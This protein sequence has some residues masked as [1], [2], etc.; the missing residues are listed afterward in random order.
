MLW[1]LGLR[2]AFSA[3]I[4]FCSRPPGSW[5][6]ACFAGL[7]SLWLLHHHGFKQGVAWQ[8]ARDAE[9]AATINAEQPKITEII[10]KVYLPQEVKIKTVTQTIVK[11]VPVYVTKQD[12]SRCVINR[13]F[14]R[15]HDSAA[16]GELPPGPAGDDGEPSGAQ[17]STVSSTTT[18]NYG[19]ANLC[20]VRLKEWQ[21]WFTKNKALWEAN[22]Q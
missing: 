8:L 14:V 20:A 11:E 18:G 3:V 17:L 12:D 9:A 4:S 10:R 1:L 6:A 13:G 15:L 2:N 19:I 22:G 21:E 7:L 5:I 16:K